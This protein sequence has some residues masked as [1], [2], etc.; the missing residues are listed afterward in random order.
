MTDSDR[1]IE[2]PDDPTMDELADRLS[3]LATSL[4]SDD[5]WPA[6]QLELCAQHGVFEW[7]IT[8][9]FGGQGWS[10]VDVVRGYLRLSAA[11]L[12]T[13]FV[14]TQRAGACRRIAASSNAWLR[15]T[16][17]APL[18]Q[19][20]RFA[21]VGVSHLTTSRR[22]LNK[23][24]LT[25]TAQG[26]HYVL[27]GYSPWVTGAGFADWLVIGASLADG[28]QL[29]VT[30]PTDLPG[31]EV[32]PPLPLVG[33]SASQTGPVRFAGAEVPAQWVLAGPATEIMK[34]GSG[35][36]SGGLQTSTLAAGLADSAISF[37]ECESERRPN[38][39][40]V[41]RALRAEWNQ[42]RVDLLAAAGGPSDHT[43]QDL[44]T[45]ANRLV[46]RATRAALMAAKGTGYIRGHATGRWCRE[47]LFFLVWSCPQPVLDAHLC[48]L[49]SLGF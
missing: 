21:T 34:Q 8:P 16:C 31:V 18:I 32:D 7:F 2:H 37:L 44:R 17:L 47:A 49:A 14:I 48:E 28:R 10:N 6:R 19:G 38:L 20:H 4:D 9:E 15:E 45:R 27:D 5:S 12:T 35:A 22:H 11:C 36:T 13:T 23:P 43:I 25:A 46:L 3:D 33:L 41:C 29:L 30:V 39:A 40:T 1:R 42:L 24:V 26:A